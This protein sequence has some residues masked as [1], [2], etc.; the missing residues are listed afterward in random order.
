MED[1][2]RTCSECKTCAEIKPR[3][4]LPNRSNHLI[5]ATRPWERISIDFKGPVAGRRKYLLVIVD[6]Y[7]RFPFAYPCSD[8]TSATVINCL[9]SLFSLVGLPEYVHSDRSKSFLS[10]DVTRFLTLKGIA[11]SRST[12]YHP[13]GNSQCERLN[14]TLWKTVKLLLATHRLPESSW[15]MV[16]PD[17]LHSI[18][19]LLCTS[20]NVCP[21]DRFFDFER[22]SMMGESIPD[23]LLYLDTHSFFRIDLLETVVRLFQ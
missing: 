5:K 14:Q 6:E 19:S 8:M 20:T 1:V 10:K 23:W 18:R 15:E 2:K 9:T 7:T 12:P 21:H 22:R 4:Y 11:T 17:A 3:Y 13:T 16:L